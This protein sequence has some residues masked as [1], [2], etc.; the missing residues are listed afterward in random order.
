MRKRAGDVKDN[1]QPGAMT[2]RNG[3]FEGDGTVPGNH[4]E[5][6]PQSPVYEEIGDDIQPDEANIEETEYS[7]IANDNSE[8]EKYQELNATQEQLAR[9]REQDETGNTGPY[10]DLVEETEI[11]NTDTDQQYYNVPDTNTNKNPYYN[12]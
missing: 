5:Y 12:Q 9:W 4:V 10:Q 11:N 8:H 3:E 1:N 6:S 7:E 2:E